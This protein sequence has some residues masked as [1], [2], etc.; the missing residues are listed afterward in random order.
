MPNQLVSDVKFH[1]LAQAGTVEETGIRK[2]F[3]AEV[4]A[5][6]SGKQKLT[7][8]ISTASV[9]RSGDTIAVDGWQLKNYLKNPVVLWAHASFLP[10]IGRATKVW[11]EDGKLK[12]DAEFESEWTGIGP[13]PDAIYRLY[14]K[15]TLSAVSVGFQPI[16]W[17]WTEDKDRKFGIDF[18]KQEL[19]EFSAVPI[20]AN[21]EALLDAKGFS[22]IRDFENFLRDVGGFSRNEAKAVASQAWK[23]IRPQREA[24]EEA[25]SGIKTLLRDFRAQLK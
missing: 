22:D 10:P 2:Q 17:A 11:V 3:L 16:K 8:T 1:E 13:K 21:P 19:L 20:P 5:Q 9:D 6:E 18:E 24:E 14:E 25:V 23:T 15:G 12:A 7:F 4:K